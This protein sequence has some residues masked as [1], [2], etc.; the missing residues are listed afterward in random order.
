ME[1][2]LQNTTPITNIIYKDRDTK[3]KV[4]ISF[5]YLTL[6]LISIYRLLII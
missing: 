4:S 3:A 5:S 6:S 1:Q 2:A